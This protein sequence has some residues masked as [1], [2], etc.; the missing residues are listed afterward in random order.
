MAWN[1]SA[2]RCGFARDAEALIEDL[3]ART[4]KVLESLA[5]RLPRGFPGKVAAPILEGLQRAARRLEA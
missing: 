1:E 5:G 3:L 4:P 2:R